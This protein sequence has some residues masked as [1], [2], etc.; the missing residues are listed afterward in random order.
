[1]WSRKIAD[2]MTAPNLLNLMTP[3]RTGQGGVPGGFHTSRITPLVRGRKPFSGP[4]MGCTPGSDPGCVW[5]LFPDGQEQAALL[6]LVLRLALGAGWRR[7]QTRRRKT[8]SYERPPL[9]THE[10]SDFKPCLRRTFIHMYSCNLGK[11][12]TPVLK[13]VT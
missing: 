3:S 9:S 11:I 4:Q 2:A 5:T 7:G 13:R 1:M 10:A 12:A 8:D 6:F